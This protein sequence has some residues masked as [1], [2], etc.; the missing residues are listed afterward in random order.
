MKEEVESVEI[1]KK[2]LLKRRKIKFKNFYFI[3]LLFLTITG[4]FLFFPS[5]LFCCL[6]KH[7][8]LFTYESWY[9]GKMSVDKKEQEKFE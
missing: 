4:I 5:S 8:F 2:N 1:E 6:I 9:G 3:S 7:V